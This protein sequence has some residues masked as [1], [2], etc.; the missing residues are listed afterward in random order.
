TLLLARDRIGIKP[1]HYAEVDGRLYFGSEIKSLLEAPDIPREIDLDALD[2]Y[3]SFLYT[4]PDRSIFTGIRKLP[5]GCRLEW[6]DGCARV[7]RYWRL[8]RAQTFTGS[9]AD[10]EAELRAVLIDAVRCHLISDVPL[11]AFLSGGVD[12][13]VV[14]ALMASV[15]GRR[16]KT[17]SIGFD[18][19]AFDELEHARRV[20]RQF[21]TD[22]H[23]LV[24]R[25]DAVAILDGLVSHFDEPFADASAIPTWYVSEMARRHVT[26]VLSGDG[27]D[28]LFGGYD[29]YLPHPYVEAIDRC[30]PRA[31]PRLG[32][33][34]AARRPHG[35]RG[36]NFLRHIGLG[37]RER[38]VDCVR[39]FS[40]E[41]KDAL[42]DADVT[43][44]L[45]AVDPEHRMAARFAPYAALPWTAQMMRLD[46]ETY[47][48]ED[49]LTKVDRMSMAH[50]IESRVP[51]LD[52][53][54]IAFASSLPSHF[55][56]RHGR[57]KH[58]LKE[59]AASLLPRD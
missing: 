23:E 14:V 39:F 48:P 55:A 46:A 38:Y 29:R 49:V 47:L 12:S 2:H 11:G 27:G 32:A 41:E 33:A 35:A 58:L 52:N 34:A 37:E 1:L 6:R 26:V 43:L 45:D 7:E 57:R 36:K 54:V 13:S 31:L 5:P 51:L 21:D 25:P 9:E 30:A 8:P 22:H 59:V 3:L 18:E 10:A 15:S 40:A 16:V 17:F 20:A 44:H 4:P 24:V 50:S 53:A 28:E 56:I 42:L 19:P